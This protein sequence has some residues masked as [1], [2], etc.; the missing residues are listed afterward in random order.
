[1]TITAVIMASKQTDFIDYLKDRKNSRKIPH[2]FEA[3]GYT[4]VRNPDAEDGLWRLKGR[5]QAIYARNNLSFAD[6]LSAA[7]RI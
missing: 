4:P 3:C 2:R 7:N 6:R 5:R 1:V